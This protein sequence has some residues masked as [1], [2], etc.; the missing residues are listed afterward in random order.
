MK[1][2]SHRCRAGTKEPYQRRSY[3]GVILDVLLELGHQLGGEGSPGLA[4]SMHDIGRG[5]F[6]RTVLEH[7][8]LEHQ[9]RGPARSELDVGRGEQP[10]PAVLGPASAFTARQTS[11]ELL[12]ATRAGVR[13][14]LLS[15]QPWW[16]KE[17]TGLC[18][19]LW[20]NC[21]NTQGGGAMP[22]GTPSPPWPVTPPNDQRRC[23]VIRAERPRKSRG[24]AT[25]PAPDGYPHV[26]CG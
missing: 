17:C 6:F 10:R 7:D 3:P 26:T 21:A 19:S 24:I 23:G 8:A 11:R 20:M 25:V 1:F 15:R 4:D 2:M 18:T 5:G 16:S 22:G 9:L 14:T 13:A 12:M